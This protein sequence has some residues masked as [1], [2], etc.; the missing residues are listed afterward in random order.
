M[1][2]DA[3]Q[4]FWKPSRGDYG[5]LT[6]ELEALYR[7]FLPGD[8][9]P[10]LDSCE[11]AQT[12]LVQAAPTEAETDFLLELAE[13]HDFIAGVVGWID[14][15][16]PEAAARV[17]EIAQ[18][19]K[20][21]G[22]RPMIQDIP[23]P[24]WML[25]VKHLPVFEAMANHRLVFDALVLPQHLPNLRTLRERVSNLVIVID[26]A[27]KPPIRD[28]IPEAW[29]RDM[30]A[31]ATQPGVNCKLSGLITEAAPDWKPGDL[32]PVIQ[33]LLATFGP[34]RLIWGSD[35][36]VLRLAGSYAQWFETASEALATLSGAE[37]SSVFGGNARRIYLST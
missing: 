37:R 13:A 28:D 18:H 23:D 12:I 3:H 14:F 6:P 21:V 34:D 1:I 17:G 36:P 11:V 30:T 24:D 15:E 29:F 9:K 20:L 5:W 2:L 10:L 35:W 19:P 16:A 26:H 33:H 27:A 4:H 8:L 25:R 7:D 22:L 32:T 31:L